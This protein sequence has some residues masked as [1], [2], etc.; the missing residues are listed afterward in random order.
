[1]GSWVMRSGWQVCLHNINNNVTITANSYTTYHLPD[2]L[3]STSHMLSHL[4]FKPNEI[5]IIVLSPFHDEE[6]RK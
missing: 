6:Q 2:A 3:F 5:G 1:M 4:I